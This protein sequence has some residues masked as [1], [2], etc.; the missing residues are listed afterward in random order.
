M[1]FIINNLQYIVLG[2]AA[3][4]GVYYAITFNA[5]SRADAD[6]T[7]YVVRLQKQQETIRKKMK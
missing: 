7:K 3:I 6:V 4:Y 1:D 5:E 2:G